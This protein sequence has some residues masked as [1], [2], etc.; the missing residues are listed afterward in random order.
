MEDETDEPTTQEIPQDIPAEENAP[1]D[2]TARPDTAPVPEET[3]PS[4]QLPN[5]KKVT[6]SASNVKKTKAAEKEAKNR[7]ASM[8]SETSE[9]KRLKVTKSKSSTA[10]VDAI[11]LNVAPSY[12]IVPFGVDY[13]IP[14]G[15]EEME[16]AEDEEIMDEEIRIDD[17][18]QSTIP[19]KST[20]QQVGDDDNRCNTPVI[21]DDFWEE[22]HPRSPR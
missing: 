1:G 17:I 21:H 15:D 2:E 16:D 14:E 20:E 8:T 6:P 12:L 10:P 4:P 22:T 3:V 13:V 11:P 5:G 18:P 9:A 19:P 7:K